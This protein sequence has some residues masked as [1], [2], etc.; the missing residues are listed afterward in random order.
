MLTRLIAAAL[1]AG[2]AAGLLVAGLQHYFVTPMILKAESFEGAG[3]A[4]APGEAEHTHAPG[5]PAH[6]HGTAGHSHGPDEWQPADGSERLAYTALATVATAAGYALI[7]A[8]AMLIAGAA[9]TTESLLKWALGGFLATTLAP[10]FGMAPTLPGMGETALEPRQIWWIATALATAAGLYVI[11]HY[12]S[13]LPLLG[14]LLLIALPH[15]WGA[16]TAV[17]AQTSVP[18][19][20]A[21]H[22]ASSVIGLSFVLWTAL[23]IALS[24]AF[25]W[26]GSAVPHEQTA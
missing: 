10:G 25:A 21:A 1:F 4:H 18:P 22:F 20:L 26:L 24:A 19:G 15:V 2:L 6:D 16:P 7:L 14:G 23:A 11:S 12:R 8:A 5:E 9:F 3:H 13:L 17:P